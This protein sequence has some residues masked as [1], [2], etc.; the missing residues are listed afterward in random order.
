MKEGGNIGGRKGK[1]GEVREED[2]TR[3]EGRGSRRS[4]DTGSRE[5]RSMSC[6]KGN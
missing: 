4:E 3:N 6:G 1:V 5:G 2:V